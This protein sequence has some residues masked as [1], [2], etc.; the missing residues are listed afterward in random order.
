MKLKICASIAAINVDQVKSEIHRA[1]ESGADYLEI[2][3][4]FAP[5][6]EIAQIVNEIESDR[7]K[8]ILTLRSKIQG[9]NFG[10]SEEQRI[11]IIRRLAEAHPMLIDIELGTLSSND[12]LADYVEQTRTKVL[13][14]WHD[15]NRTPPTE[16]LSSTLTQMRMY[17]S[18]VKVVTTAKTIE[19]SLRLMD[20]YEHTS[21]LKAIIFAMGEIGVLS[22]VL[23][24][25]I[26]DAPFTYATNGEPVAPGQLTVAQIRNIYS[27]IARNWEDHT[28]NSPSLKYIED[29]DLSK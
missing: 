21:G 4:N 18:Y 20:L 17:S 22:R 9:G 3:L 23:C 29:H 19:D 16:E 12:N 10:G 26:G 11:S 2:R 25:L 14:S 15:F 13:V 24:T 27:K 6:S 8:C 7:G 5:S 28:R 1:L